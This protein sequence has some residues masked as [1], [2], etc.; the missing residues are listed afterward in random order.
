MPQRRASDATPTWKKPEIIAAALAAAAA[1]AVAVI[2]VVGDDDE[3]DGTDDATAKDAAPTIELLQTGTMPAAPPPAVSYW[4]E[5][6]VQ[7]L[8]SN[9]RVF[10][11]GYFDEAASTDQSSSD[12]VTEPQQQP[13]SPPAEYFPGGAWRV[14]WI[15]EEPPG[16]ARFEAVLVEVPE[17]GDGGSP[18]DPGAAP[19]ETPTDGASASDPPTFATPGPGET[20]TDGAPSPSENGASEE[21]ESPAPPSPDDALSRLI[22]DRLVRSGPTSPLIVARDDVVIESE[23]GAP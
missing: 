2:N 8:Q 13:V 18:G 10:V 1:V 12:A 7:E 6:R 22:L 16:S 4:F 21:P 17:S 19:G 9:Q 14:D 3:S 15:L 23:T 11:F 5:G 20:P